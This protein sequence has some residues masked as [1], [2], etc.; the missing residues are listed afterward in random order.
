[1]NVNA[2]D[3][4]FQDTEYLAYIKV[5]EDRDAGI[6]LSSTV[7]VSIDDETRGELGTPAKVDQN[8]A[9]GSILMKVWF[10]KTGKTAGYERPSK[11]YKLTVHWDDL[12]TIGTDSLTHEKYPDKI[13]YVEESQTDVKKNTPGDIQKMTPATMEFKPSGA[14]EDAGKNTGMKDTAGSAG[15]GQLQLR[16]FFHPV[17]PAEKDSGRHRFHVGARGESGSGGLVLHVR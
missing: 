12:N 1:M 7:G 9:D 11:E 4:A 14:G 2:G 5:S 15:S 13:Y 17:G 8:S 3:Q 16:Y 10:N 6:Y